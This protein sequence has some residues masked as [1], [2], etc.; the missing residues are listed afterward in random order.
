[1][2]KITLLLLGFSLIATTTTFAQESAA[3]KGLSLTVSA[4][5]AIPVGSFKDASGTQFGLGGSAQLA[6]PVSSTIDLTASAGYLG[7]STSKTTELYYGKSFNSCT[8]SG[9][10][11]CCHSIW[12]LCASKSRSH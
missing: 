3:R 7:F 12:S 11:T 8:F 10:C 2:K 1:M 6:I 5:G 4:N 9:R